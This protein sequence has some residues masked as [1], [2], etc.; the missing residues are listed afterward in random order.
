MD[1]SHFI[2]L[3]RIVKAEYRKVTPEINLLDH[4]ASIPQS[5]DT[6]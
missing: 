5:K 4:S 6:F 3:A 2:T 1:Y